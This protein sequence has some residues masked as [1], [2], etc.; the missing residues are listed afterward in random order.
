MGRNFFLLRLCSTRQGLE[1]QLLVSATKLP[2]I[3]RVRSLPTRT[4]ALPSRLLCAQ[5][6]PMSS[7]ASYAKLYAGPDRMWRLKH[8][9]A[10]VE[11]LRA[12]GL[13]AI[14]AEMR[15]ANDVVSLAAAKAHLTPTKIVRI[16]RRALP[17][18]PRLA[19]SL[20]TRL[21]RSTPARTA[22]AGRA[23]GV[24][25]DDVVGRRAGGCCAARGARRGAE[26]GQGRAAEGEHGTRDAAARTWPRR[27]GARGVLGVS[28]YG[29]AQ[30][31]ECVAA[32]GAG[33]APRR[34]LRTV[35]PSGEREQPRSRRRARRDWA[36]SRRDGSACTRKL[37]R[38][39]HRAARVGR[40][41]RLLPWRRGLWRLDA[42]HGRFGRRA[43]QRGSGARGVVRLVA[44][45]A[46]QQR[47]RQRQ[48]R[49]RRRG[50]LRRRQR[51]LPW[52]Q[53]S[54]HC[55]P[56]CLDRAHGAR[57]RVPFRRWARTA[58]PR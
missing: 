23:R 7:V 14:E 12:E 9:V 54:R 25:G 51:A 37:R 24:G 2:H 3:L 39:R 8:I 18:P 13:E 22:R 34:K 38:R 17:P 47:R 56:R 50:V 53:R 35:R 31:G 33:R 11:A 28:P 44:R 20:L 45:R 43:A 57:Q 36:D 42:R 48:R 4:P 49:R 10:N 32:V 55:W 26:V 29:L 40:E 52:P 1:S 27:R 19:R 15:S 41:E 5:R 46:R 21:L 6:R 58:H 30:S 16:A